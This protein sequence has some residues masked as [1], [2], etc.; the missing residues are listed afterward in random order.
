MEFCPYCERWQDESAIPRLLAGRSGRRG[1]KIAGVSERVLLV[2]GAT[3]FALIAAAS[4][5]AALAT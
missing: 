3:L 1:R 5:A 2:V 4:I